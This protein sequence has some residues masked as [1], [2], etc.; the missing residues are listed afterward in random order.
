MGCQRAQELIHPYIDGELDPLQAADV[1]RHIEQCE[2]CNL[3]YR[4]QIALR[5]SLKDSSLYYR[6]SEDLRKRIQVSVQKT[7]G[8]GVPEPEH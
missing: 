3:L 7:S 5:S 2:N 8:S 4:N 1:E 6:A